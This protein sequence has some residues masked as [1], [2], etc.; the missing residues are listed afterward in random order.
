MARRRDPEER[1]G[2]TGDFLCI[3]PDMDDSR[4]PQR[5]CLVHINGSE[6]GRRH[7]LGDRPITIGRDATSDIRVD[8]GAVAPLHATLRAA[9]DGVRVRGAAGETFVNDRAIDEAHLEDGDLLRI[10]PALFKHLRDL[11]LD[12]RVAEEQFRLRTHDPETQAFN[13]AYFLE[14]L[15]RSLRRTLRYERPLA[16]VLLPIVP[17]AD[18]Q[19]L[20]E[21]ARRIEARLRRIDLL[22]RFTAD[23][24]VVLAPELDRPGATAL[25]EALRAFT[26]D[27][28]AVLDL[29]D[30]RDPLELLVPRIDALLAGARAPRA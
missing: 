22:A 26:V 3:V 10:G 23:A 29:T 1:T 16:L 7:D 18:V 27:S 15:K 20:A 14:S 11:H 8:D 9:D 4:R 30:V 13:R 24:F 28:P 25:A 6:P 19:A 12:A 17:P 21:L 5:S 2:I